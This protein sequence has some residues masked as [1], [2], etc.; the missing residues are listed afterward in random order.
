MDRE[1]GKQQRITRRV[2][3]TN[4]RHRKRNRFAYRWSGTC[5]FGASN[6]KKTENNIPPMGVDPLLSLGCTNRAA[7]AMAV[8]VEKSSICHF[9]CGCVLIDGSAVCSLSFSPGIEQAESCC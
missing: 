4:T 3:L 6:P 1:L 8:F 7:F 9:A 5:I 2:R